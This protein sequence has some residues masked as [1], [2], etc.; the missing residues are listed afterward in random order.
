MLLDWIPQSNPDVVATT[1]PMCQCPVCQRLCA[2]LEVLDAS[3]A[4]MA[5]PAADVGFGCSEIAAQELR[6][7]GE[8]RADCC[9]LLLNQQL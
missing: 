9:R 2:K 3:H 7:S 5:K 6:V 8:E 1:L 4:E